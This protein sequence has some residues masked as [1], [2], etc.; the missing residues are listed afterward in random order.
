L[1][2]G[3][4]GKFTKIDLFNETTINDVKKWGAASTGIGRGAKTNRS[5]AFSSV[6]ERNGI[7]LSF[8]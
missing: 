8:G 7:A 6:V 1:P 4:S 5:I 3:A 2:P